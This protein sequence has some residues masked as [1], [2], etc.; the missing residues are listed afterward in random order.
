[1]QCVT[2]LYPNKADAK[3]DFDYYI[4]R[5]LPMTAKLLGNPMEIYKGTATPTG[6]PLPFLCVLR[7]KVNSIEE[8][9]SVMTR[10]GAEIIADVPNYTNIEPVIQF[11][12]II[13]FVP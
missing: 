4:K 12:E 1:M 3:F 5:H 6:A 8:F 13:P 9:M 11:D 10:Q 2:I 7:I